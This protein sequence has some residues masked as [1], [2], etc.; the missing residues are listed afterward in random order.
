[1]VILII[2]QILFSFTDIYY[3]IQ[4]KDNASARSGIINRAGYCFILTHTLKI[5]ISTASGFGLYPC[6]HFF[7]SAVTVIFCRYAHFGYLVLLKIFVSDYVDI[8]YLH[9]CKKHSDKHSDCT[10][11]A[12]NYF[13]CW[14]NRCSSYCMGSNS[15][16]FEH[17]GLFEGYVIGKLYEIFYRYGYILCKTSVSS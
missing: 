14:G 6:I 4:G 16:G 2:P 7:C 9:F 17:C 5:H 11:A 12:Y 13:V 10:K 15:H 1:M 8:A 3:N